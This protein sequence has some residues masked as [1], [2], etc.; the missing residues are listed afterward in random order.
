MRDKIIFFQQLFDT[1]KIVGD[2]LWIVGGE[3]KLI[4]S[5]Q[6]KKGGVRRLDQTSI[7]FDGYM[8]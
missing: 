5:L 8:Q 2:S 1:K 3:F 4:R 7:A 6:E